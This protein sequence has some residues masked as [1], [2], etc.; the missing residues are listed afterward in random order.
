MKNVFSFFLLFSG[1]FLVYLSVTLMI[2]TQNMNNIYKNDS[3]IQ[4]VSAELEFYQST[5]WDAYE[6]S[7]WSS[8]NYP[9]QE[10]FRRVW[11][12]RTPVQAP[13]QVIPQVNNI[14]RDSH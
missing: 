10:V 8:E 3:W 2:E 9:L 14:V 12:E 1:F 4:W 6:P 13:E 5:I 11:I 7:I